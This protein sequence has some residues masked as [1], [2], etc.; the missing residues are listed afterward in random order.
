MNISLIPLVQILATSEGEGG[1]FD[2]NATLPLMALQFVLLTIVLTFIFYK[3][4]ANVLEERETFISKNLADASESLL[5]ADELFEQ[6]EEQLKTAKAEAQ[7]VIAQSE[8]EAKDIVASEIDQARKDA[9][10]LIDKTNSE[11]EAQKTLA[12]EKLET[13]VDELSDLI[14]EKI[15][16]KEVVL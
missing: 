6:Y 4:I 7:T 12:L 5:K 8:K 3:P 15:L 13:Q 10:K 1:L 9:S 11:L 14:K 16:G 2:F